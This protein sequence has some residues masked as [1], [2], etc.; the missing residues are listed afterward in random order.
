MVDLEAPST[1]PSP[2]SAG[3]SGRRVARSRGLPGGRAVVGALLVAA[4]A[5]GV[6]AAQLRATAEPT[7][8][9]LVAVADI[10]A[11]TRVDAGNLQT[12]FGHLPL[13]LAPALAERSVLLDDRDALVGQVVTSPL[14]RGDLVSRT[15]VSD[16]G[17][18]AD[19]HAM[20]FSI[21]AADA[22][23]GDLR[24]GQRVDVIA[25]Y[26]SGDDAVTTYVVVGAPLLSIASD[27]GAGFGGDTQRVLTLALGDRAQ[28]QALA[29]AVAV[30][31][32]VVTRSPEDGDEAE[33]AP[34]PYRPA[35]GPTAAADGADHAGDGADDAGEG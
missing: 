26:G 4:A 24:R 2:T 28:V 19:H 21:A 32:V 8:R 16:G 22:V 23:A 31:E 17:S 10:D 11:G 18:M 3:R 1:A 33:P 25:T 34:D 6:F 30:A 15:A 14:S 35:D 29:H 13:D 5:V 9:Y 7:T 27:E 20:S 12:L